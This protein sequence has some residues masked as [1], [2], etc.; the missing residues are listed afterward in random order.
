MCVCVLREVELTVLKHLK[1]AERLQ[2]EELEP[3]GK[4]FQAA[5]CK[6][7]F[8]I[9]TAKTECAASNG[10]KPSILGDIQKEA[11]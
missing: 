3:N 1:L 6:G 10:D 9:R 11:G 8:S 4:Q 5:Q 7:E 2:R